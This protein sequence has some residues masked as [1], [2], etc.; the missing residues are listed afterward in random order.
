M[1]GAGIFV[2]PGLVAL[3]LTGAGWILIAWALG[4]GIRFYVMFLIVPL[5][6]FFMMLPVSI[7]G[8]GLRESVFVF[9]F[10]LF[11]VSS[12][13]AI[14]FCWVSFA[15]ILVQGVIGGTVFA[16]RRSKLLL[17]EIRD[18]PD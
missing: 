11:A 10:G 8:I 6:L 16:L 1:V 15:M 4:I 12:E 5:A 17:A 13:Q 9:L 18:G 14:A 7:N 2:T 3:H